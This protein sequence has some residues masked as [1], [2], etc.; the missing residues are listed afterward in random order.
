MAVNRSF[1]YFLLL[2]LLR[3][4]SIGV[5]ILLITIHRLLTLSPT[6]A[7]T[8]LLLFLRRRSAFIRPYAVY[9][10]LLQFFLLFIV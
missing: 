10:F 8:F 4:F 5:R 9:N 7:R 6:R 3:L 1:M 2:L